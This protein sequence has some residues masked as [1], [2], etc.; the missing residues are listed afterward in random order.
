MT[1]TP[2][3]PGRPRTS[4]RPRSHFNIVFRARLNGRTLPQVADALG[5]PLRTVQ[6]WSQGRRAPAMWQLVL[7]KMEETKP[8]Q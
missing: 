6:D 5:V 1:P 8:G 2:N 7:D 3:R 4:S